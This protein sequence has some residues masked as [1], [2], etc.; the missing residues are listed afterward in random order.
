M[1]M[2]SCWIILFVLKLY[3]HLYTS[4]SYILIDPLVSS[5]FNIVLFII[6]CCTCI[7]WCFL[8]VIINQDDKRISS[9]CSFFFVVL[10][11][12]LIPLLFALWIPYE[13]SSIVSLLYPFL[14]VPSSSIFFLPIASVVSILQ[15][16]SQFKMKHSAFFVVMTH[17]LKTCTL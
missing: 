6:L 7:L 4:L 11:I 16:M 13:L 14:L 12:T 17:D 15:F 8:W 1:R 5:C 9:S 3:Y 10:A 2:Y